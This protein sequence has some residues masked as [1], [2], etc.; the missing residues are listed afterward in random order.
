M[1]TPEPPKV[2]KRPP[3][4]EVEEFH[5]HADTDGSG[6]AVHHTLGSGANQAAAGNH[7][8]DGG[9]STKFIIPLDGFALSG[10]KASGAALNSV[11]AA[12]VQLGATDSTTP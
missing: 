3:F 10:S 1:A 2:N 6:K 12:L 5:T 7:S 9:G 4:R 8:H 11:I